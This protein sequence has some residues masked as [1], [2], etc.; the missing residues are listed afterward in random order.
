MLKQFSFKFPYKFTYNFPSILKQMLIII[1]ITIIKKNIHW[2]IHTNSHI[3]FTQILNWVSKNSHT[4]SFPFYFIQFCIKF[5]NKLNFQ[6]KFWNFQSIFR[7]ITYFNFHVIINKI[8]FFRINS[9]ANF[10]KNLNTD[11]NTDFH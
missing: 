2:N 7:L 4:I 8:R 3:I 11:L 5:L 6:F 9:G 1:F 10:H